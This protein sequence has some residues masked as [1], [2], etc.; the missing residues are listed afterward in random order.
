[1]YKHRYYCI[2]PCPVGFCQLMISGKC[3]W[4]KKKGKLLCQDKLKYIFLS[5]AYDLKQ[6]LSNKV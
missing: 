6:I 4:S 1:M 5:V 3:D 2:V